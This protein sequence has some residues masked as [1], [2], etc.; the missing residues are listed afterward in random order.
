V[1]RIWSGSRKTVVFVTHSIAESIFLSDRVFVM[2]SR[3]GTLAEVI[4]IDLPRSRA[5]S[6]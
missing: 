2:T 5:I 1:L 4:D 6:R 3:P